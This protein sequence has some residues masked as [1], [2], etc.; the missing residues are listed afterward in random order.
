M[1]QV[2]RALVHLACATSIVAV[3]S[4]DNFFALG[5]ECAQ[6]ELELAEGS[7]KTRAYF[8]QPRERHL[9]EALQ[10]TAKSIRHAVPSNVS[11]MDQFRRE[12]WLWQDKDSKI[13]LAMD[14][15]RKECFE[16]VTQK[17]RSEWKRCL[18][19][20]FENRPSTIAELV[21]GLKSSLGAIF[22]PEL[23]IE[24]SADPSGWA[25]FAREGNH[26]Q[27]MHCS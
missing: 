11:V 18:V 7:R 1:K 6:N 10:I 27:N 21:R 12:G 16:F 9:L 20:H 24:C 3:G 17:S 23:E 8:L 5:S 25:L 2:V 14:N 4:A 13:Q 15:L 26:P 19:T 22:S